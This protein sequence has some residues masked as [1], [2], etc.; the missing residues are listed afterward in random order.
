MSEVEPAVGL[1]EKEPKQRI[2]VLSR[3]LFLLLLL[4]SEPIATH[5]AK[6]YY[7]IDGLAIVDTVDSRH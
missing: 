5:H 4:L 3:R 6:P 7:L 1:L 2:S